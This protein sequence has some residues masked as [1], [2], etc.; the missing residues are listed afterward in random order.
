MG[1]FTVHDRVHSDV[2]YGTFHTLPGAIAPGSGRARLTTAKVWIDKDDLNSLM[3]FSCGSRA[4][5]R[6]ARGFRQYR[7]SERQY[8]EASGRLSDER[9]LKSYGSNACAAGVMAGQTGVNYQCETSRRANPRWW[10][11][12][13]GHRPRSFRRRLPV[14]RI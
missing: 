10:P 1:G 14:A 9:R 2:Q 5:A 12:W 6:P 11:S 4:E 3:S 8:A 7:N 13:S